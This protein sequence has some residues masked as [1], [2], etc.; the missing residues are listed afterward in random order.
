MNRNKEIL[1]I[2]LLL[3]LCFILFF[4]HLGARPLWDTDE[5]MHAS[6]SKDMVLSGD[7]ITPTFNGENFYD[8]PVLHNWFV[9]LSF[10]IFGFTEFAARLPAAILG[11]GGV[12]LTYLLG[13]KMF[14]P[15]V[16]FLSGVILVTNVEYFVLSRTVVHDIS[17]CFFVTLALFL[18]YMGFVDGEHR[19]R[20]F[21][22]FYLS[23][24]FA[25]L[26]KGPVGIVLPG[27]I[28]GLFLVLKK[29]LG[30]FREMIIGWGVLIFLAVAAPWYILISLRN[31]DYGWYFFIHNNMMRFLNP[32][33]QHHQP[34]YYYFLALL[35]GFFPWSCF[36]PLAIYR[37]FHK[38]LQKMNERL[39]FLLLWFLV[40]FLFFS[41]ASSKLSTYIL[42]LF[43][44]A[45]LLVGALWHDCMK[46]S[47]SRG[48]RTFLYSFSPLL[49][50]LPVVLLYL[51]IGP[52]V[53]YEAKFGIDFLA[54]GYI[55]FW[56]EGGAGLS[57]YLASRKRLMASFWTIAGTAVSLFLFVEWAILPSLTPFLSTKGLGQKL[58]QMVPPGE[59]LA[60][61]NS[62]KETALF[63]TN[64]RALVLRNPSEVIQF[65]SSD[66]RVFCIVNRSLYKDSDKI[67]E[68]SH[69]IEEEGGK[70][71]ISNRK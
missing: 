57:F 8:K 52:P 71:M 46:A 34:F 11:L 68:L 55:V 26:A 31:S 30:F 51:W 39:L 24:G 6:T 50:I 17:L 56:I 58:D 19:K 23:L 40:F 63:Y 9:S 64:R 60:F 12:L 3:L 69:I 29:R 15:V 61:I 25:V 2:F 70:L 35:G 33:A 49:L 5:G 28:I 10:L 1:L 42:P 13:R 65:L 66:K 18:F 59:K 67:K 27:I 41:V 16:G 32:R 7:W 37:V 54:Y 38:T 48:N 20:Y 21:T 45:S 14:G 22:F 62:V 36:L 43:P 53:Y 47:P 44:A 4:L